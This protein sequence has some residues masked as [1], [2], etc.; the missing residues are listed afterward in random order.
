[1]DDGLSELKPL[2]QLEMLW[3]H[4]LISHYFAHGQQQIPG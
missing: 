2:A 3:H 1:M 4:K